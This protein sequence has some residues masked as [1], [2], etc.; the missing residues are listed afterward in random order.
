MKIIKYAYKILILIIVGGLALTI[1]HTGITI[2][3]K[4]SN[5]NINKNQWITWLF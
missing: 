3:S 2:A 5:I 1:K 4:I